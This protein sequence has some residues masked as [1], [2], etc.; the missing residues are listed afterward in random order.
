MS[1]KNLFERYGIDPMQGPA[2]ITE[3]LR[4]LAE[5]AAEDERAEIRAAWEELT[6]HPLSRLNAAF[7]AHPETRPPLG[8]PPREGP[9]P[10]HRD[11]AAVDPP[12][13]LG[14][15]AVLPPVASAL[16]GERRAPPRPAASL[17]DDPILK[18]AI[19]AR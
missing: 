11:A 3:R 4:E 15:L 1:A 13:T 9:G 10:D 17:D 2:A 19:D 6:L 5:D 18:R 12:L 16:G 8:A 14:D 7:G